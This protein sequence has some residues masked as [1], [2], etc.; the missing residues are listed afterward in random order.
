MAS[1]M[2]N[3]VM[4][5]VAVDM[6]D[7]TDDVVLRANGSVIAFDGFLTLYIEENLDEDE[8]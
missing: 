6:S 4:D 5:Q 7:G 2:E 8:E 1:Q 3:A